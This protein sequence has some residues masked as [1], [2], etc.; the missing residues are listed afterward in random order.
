MAWLVKVRK[1]LILF[2]IK[3]YLKNT[4]FTWFNQKI[5]ILYKNFKESKN[6]FFKKNHFCI[7]FYQNV[8]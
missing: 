1:L 8:F 5:T 4:H 7:F 3:K 2:F 6:R